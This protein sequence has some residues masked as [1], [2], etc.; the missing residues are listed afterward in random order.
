MIKKVKEL[1][2]TF[3]DSS[4]I[5]LGCQ[6]SLKKLNEY[7]NNLNSHAHASIATIYDPR[8]NISVFRVVLPASTDDRKRERICKNMGDCYATYLQREQTMQRARQLQQPLLTIEDE[9]ELSD[10][11][12]YRGAPMAPQHESELNRYLGQER[13]PRDTNVYQYWKAKQYDF[14]IIAKIAQAHLAIPAT[15]APSECVFSGGSDIIT[16][17]R[18]RLTGST[19]RMIICLKACSI[20]TDEDEGNDEDGMEE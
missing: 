5:R 16:K 8:F 6:E 7:Y 1:K 10:A 18:N 20:M 13:V 15:S 4:P 9:E 11:E 3:G 2:Q 14:P 12:L 19:V 17:K